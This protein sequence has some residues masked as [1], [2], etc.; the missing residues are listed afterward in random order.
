MNDEVR[1]LVGTIAFGLG[2]NK[3][4]VRAVIHTSLP[5]S[6]EQY[7]QEAGR[8]GRD[9]KPSDCFL[10]WQKKDVGL[11]VYFIEQ[12]TDPAEKR[13]SWDRYHQV[14]SFAESRECRHKI[15]CNH[16]GEKVSWT[17]CGACDICLPPV[18]WGSAQKPPGMR[19]EKYSSER[20]AAKKIRRSAKAASPA[21]IDESLLTALKLWRL[22]RSR[23]DK[24]PA[25]V[26]LHD[27][28]LEHL[29]VSRP[30][31]TQQLRSVP[32]IGEAKLQ[33]YGTEILQVLRE[34]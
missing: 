27:S 12:L 2:I 22:E 14:R 26:V 13:R 29:C 18:H 25:F 11:L 30:N 21:K 7:Y 1:V 4:A 28:T 3:P 33:R 5:K 19:Q 34:N 8:A 17:D 16:F 23:A 20:S 31:S 24:V 32:G 6:V 9:G 10:L 15:I